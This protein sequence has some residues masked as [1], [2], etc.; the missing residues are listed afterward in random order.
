M[1][2]EQHWFEALVHSGGDLFLRL[3]Y[4]LNVT[5]L[6]FGIAMLTFAGTLKYREERD[7]MISQ[8]GYVDTLQIFWRV[9]HTTPLRH[10]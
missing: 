4:L 1:E 9:I 3:L 8:E 10:L 5:L 2:L 7:R 6:Y